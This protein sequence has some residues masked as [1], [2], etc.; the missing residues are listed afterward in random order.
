[1]AG[2]RKKATNLF[3]ALARL[4]LAL[5]LATLKKK[6]VDFSLGCSQGC[7][8]GGVTFKH[9]APQNGQI[10]SDWLRPRGP[11]GIPTVYVDGKA[12]ID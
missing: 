10:R 6:T 3:F 7:L 11:R 9:R 8:S 12:S 1:M 2:Q 4:A 5:L